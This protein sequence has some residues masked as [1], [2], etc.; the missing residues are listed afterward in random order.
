M[1]N[2]EYTA[3]VEKG[4]FP[5]DPFVP[6]DAPFTNTNGTIENLVLEK[7]AS[8][9]LIKSTAGALRANHWHRTDWHYAYI[10]QGEIIYF[11]RP[12]GSKE[13]PQQRLFKPAEMFFT[14]PRVEHA[15]F[16][17]CE[18]TFLTFAKNTR[19]HEHHEEDLVRVNM[20]GP[21]RSIYDLR[22]FSFP[23][24]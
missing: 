6:I 8:A 4:I 17:P 18:T 11:W 21:P 5:E 22:S 2:R 7:F 1:T 10:L 3:L 24:T 23:G 16:F 15:M 19:D 12:E 14:P 20:I 9:A 13:R